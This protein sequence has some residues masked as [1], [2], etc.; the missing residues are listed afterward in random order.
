MRQL[1]LLLVVAVALSAGCAGGKEAADRGGS[2]PFPQQP[3]PQL[4]YL[5]LDQV[6][7]ASPPPEFEPV[8]VENLSGMVALPQA[9]ITMPTDVSNFAPG[10]ARRIVEGISSRFGALYVEGENTSVVVSFEAYYFE[11]PALAA[12]ALQVYRQNWNTLRFNASG[13]ELWIWEGY[14]EQPAPPAWAARG[15]HIFWDFAQ[16]RAMLGEGRVAVARIAEDLYCY[17]GEA[18]LGNYFVMVDVHLPRERVVQDGQRIFAEYLEGVAVNASASISSDGGNAS[19]VE[20]RIARLEAKRE[21]VTRAYLEGRISL[22]L[23]NYT[24]EKIEEELR[25]LRGEEP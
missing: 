1:H 6:P 20:E 11:D 17:H 16:N 10:V 24:L 5:P 14:L 4:E 23:Y 9:A 7:R 21:E 25:R 18:A 15:S 8:F 13:K 2:A 3:A 19:T 22:E 12:E